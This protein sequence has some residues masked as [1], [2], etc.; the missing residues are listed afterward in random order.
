MRV[1]VTAREADRCRGRHAR[2]RREQLPAGETQSGPEKPG[3]V[4]G[5]FRQFIHDAPLH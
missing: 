5:L 2:R 4:L 3:V 1:R